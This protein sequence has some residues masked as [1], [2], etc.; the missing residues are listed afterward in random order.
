S[1]YEDLQP[2]EEQRAQKPA[3]AP[4]E[5]PAARRDRGEGRPT[6][7]DRRAIDKLMGRE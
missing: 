7:D 1:L 2:I 6:K 5:A 3:S 4:F